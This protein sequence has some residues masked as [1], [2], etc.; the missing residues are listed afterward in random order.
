MVHEV[1]TLKQELAGQIN[2]PGSVQLLHTLM[3]H[4]L[5]DELRIRVFP[6]VLG[7]GARL[8]AESSD[9]KPMH[10]VS[11]QTSMATPSSSPTDR[12]DA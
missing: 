4:H 5:V 2:V 7:A 12:S 11:S 6:V 1:A 9:K 8:F 3:E 10:L